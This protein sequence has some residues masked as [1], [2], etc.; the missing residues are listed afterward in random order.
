MDIKLIPKNRKGNKIKI[1]PKNK[2]SFTEYCGGKVTD[3][4][5]QKGK[6]SPNPTTRK[7]ANFAANARKWKHQEGGTITE[8]P[9]VTV[10]PSNLTLN[11]FYPI[12]SD[13]P[14]TGHSSLH[15]TSNSPLIYLSDSKAHGYKGAWVDKTSKD[16][17]YNLVTNNCADSTRYVLEKIFGKTAKPFLFTTPGDVQDFLKENIQDYKIRDQDGETSITIPISYNDYEKAFSAVN[18][19]RK[20]VKLSD[21]KQIAPDVPSYELFKF[22]NQN[23]NL[24]TLIRNYK[25]SNNPA[26]LTKINKRLQNSRYRFNSDKFIIE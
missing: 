7:R 20:Q 2:G 1:N 17:D 21:Y 14:F 15:I 26:Y 13:Y 6:N 10:Y 19:L 8:L 24:P 3:E 5:I 12:T 4:C 11:T 25:R 16:S 22:I 23:A 18:Q 9:E